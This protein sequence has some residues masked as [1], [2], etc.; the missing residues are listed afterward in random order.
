V[1][2]SIVFNRV[3]DQGLPDSGPQQ[4]LKDCNVHQ[5]V[6]ISPLELEAIRS[7]YRILVAKLL[8]EHFP[9]FEMFM[10]H[11]ATSTKSMN[12]KE[13][14]TKSE[15]LTMPI[16]MKDEKKYSDCVD[17]LDLWTNSRHGHMKYTQLLGYVPN[18]QNQ[19][20]T[21]HPQS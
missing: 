8:F 19:Q 16:M 9:A 10:P 12:D 6:D 15:V 4:S 2:T 7:R 1:A 17:V 13:M 11:V 5:L 20:M 21:P 3:S 18:S 14:S